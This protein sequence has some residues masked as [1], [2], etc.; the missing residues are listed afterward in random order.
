[1]YILDSNIN[2]SIFMHLLWASFSKY[3][4]NLAWVLFTLYY[5][6]HCFKTIESFGCNFLY[7]LYVIVFLLFPSMDIEVTDIMTK[8]IVS[9]ILSDELI[10]NNTHNDNNTLITL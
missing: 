7:I 3:D 8:I 9:H 2:T 5:T 6:Y 4:Y 10:R 1:M